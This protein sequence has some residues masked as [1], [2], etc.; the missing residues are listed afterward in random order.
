M[1]KEDQSLIGSREQTRKALTGL[2]F[3]RQVRPGVKINTI[4]HTF[5]EPGWASSIRR[6]IQGQDRSH[7]I[8]MVEDIVTLALREI[9]VETGVEIKT[10]L[11]AALED[12]QEGLR[13]MMKTYGTDPT[14]IA[15]LKFIVTMVEM[16][17]V[18][19]KGEL[20]V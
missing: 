13:N 12:S 7:S 4:G 15:R 16:G 3:L 2:Y 9:T 19:A 1:D 8:Q 10:V 5:D 18:R 6:A 11:L 17:I 14:V 20:Q